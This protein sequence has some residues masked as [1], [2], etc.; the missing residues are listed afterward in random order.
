VIKGHEYLE[1]LP[2]LVEISIPKDGRLTV[3]GDVHGQ[4]PDLLTVFEM[5][6]F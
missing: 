2:N 5:N 6:G 1:K 3:C 4:L